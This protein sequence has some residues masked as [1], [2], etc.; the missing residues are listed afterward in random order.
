MTAIQDYSFSNIARKP[1]KQFEYGVN[2]LGKNSQSPLE[3]YNKIRSELESLMSDLSEIEKVNKIQFCKEQKFI[4]PILPGSTRIKLGPRKQSFR[5]F[6]SISR[7]FP[8]IK[9]MRKIP[10]PNRPSKG[11]FPIFL[12]YRLKK[13]ILYFVFWLLSS[14]RKCPTVS[15]LN[16]WKNWK[17]T[18]EAL[19]LQK[20]MERFVLKCFSNFCVRSPEFSL[21]ISGTR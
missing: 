3:R 8:I 6:K 15:L 10:P 1:L 20:R 9:S 17:L 19:K 4:L 21:F 11:L 14:L 18:V 13:R 5:H 7:T 12:K 2:P 16:Y